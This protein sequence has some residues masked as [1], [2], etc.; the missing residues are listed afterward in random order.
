MK[1][2]EG[3]KNELMVLISR[4]ASEFGKLCGEDG[5]LLDSITLYFTDR[6]YIAVF[7]S[8]S[9]SCA[10]DSLKTVDCRL[11]NTSHVFTK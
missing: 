1:N 2:R 6:D 7:Q 8:N 3:R 11:S 9:K 10:I 4:Q 5:E